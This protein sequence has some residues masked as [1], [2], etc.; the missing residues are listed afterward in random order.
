MIRLFK[1]IQSFDKAT[2][3]KVNLIKY[4]VV[5]NN[6]KKI[7]IKFILIKKCSFYYEFKEMINDLLVIIIIIFINLYSL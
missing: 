1:K 3:W 2:K 4:N 6:I 7:I 5:V